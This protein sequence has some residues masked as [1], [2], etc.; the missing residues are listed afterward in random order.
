MEER[1]L[2][3]FVSNSPVALV[4]EFQDT[5]PVQY[6]IF[7]RVYEI[8]RNVP[9]TGVFLIGDPKQAIYSF[10]DADIFTYLEARKSD[11]GAPL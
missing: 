4:D 3:L 1:S 2:P 7:D 5:D 6:E 10:R 8:E 9:E 11:S